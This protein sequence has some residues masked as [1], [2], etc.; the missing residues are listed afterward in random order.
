MQ[1]QSSKTPV[2][3]ACTTC[4]THISRGQPGAGLI[5]ALAQRCMVRP[6]PLLLCLQRRMLLPGRCLLSRLPLPV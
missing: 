1:L 2:L 5:D 6:P 3:G 4:D